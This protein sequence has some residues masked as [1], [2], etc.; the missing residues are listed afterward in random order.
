V[1]Y[2]ITT[3][4][5]IDITITKLTSSLIMTKAESFV[6][7]IFSQFI[8]PTYGGG[9]IEFN[10]LDKPRWEVH[11]PLSNKSEIFTNNQGQKKLN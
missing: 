2:G 3:A 8:R 11:N 4:V 1:S 5:Q 7:R 6:T 10:T 9:V